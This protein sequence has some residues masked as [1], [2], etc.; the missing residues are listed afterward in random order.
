MELNSRLGFF[1]LGIVA[2][3]RVLY[4]GSWRVEKK[5]MEKDTAGLKFSLIGTSSYLEQQW[6]KATMLLGL[7]QQEN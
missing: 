4:S 6:L 5:M 2:V 7:I 1:Y 3:A